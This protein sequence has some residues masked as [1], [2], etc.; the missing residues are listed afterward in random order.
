MALGKHHKDGVT[1]DNEGGF[2]TSTVQVRYQESQQTDKEQTAVYRHC[3]CA[4]H[5]P[6][7]HVDATPTSLARSVLRCLERAASEHFGPTMSQDERHW[8]WPQQHCGY[9][10]IP[11]AMLLGL[12]V[13]KFNTTTVFSCTSSYSIMLIR[14]SSRPSTTTSS[15][16]S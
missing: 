3:R 11:N 12:Q 14:D 7:K 13:H 10:R 4:H 1:Q 8:P 9:F 15:S 16:S 5:Q 6:T 2:N